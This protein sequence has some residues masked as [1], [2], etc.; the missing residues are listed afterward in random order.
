MVT[1]LAFAP[2]PAPPAAPRVEAVEGAGS[3]CGTIEIELRMVGAVDDVLGVA[4]TVEIDPQIVTYDRYDLA[5]SHL[6]QG[7]GDDVIAGE[8]QPGGPLVFGF[9]RTGPAGV[10]FAGGETIVKLYFER[11]PG[12]SGAATFTFPPGDASVL[13]PGPQGSGPVA[14]TPAIPW[15]G[16]TLDIQ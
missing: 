3:Q 14:K 4:F 8:P 16:G 10:D 2:A 12:S 9:S 7:P 1:C 5:G 6:D 15:S 11:V 13:E